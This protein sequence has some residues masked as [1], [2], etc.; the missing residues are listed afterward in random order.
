MHLA[1][2][3]Y[4]DLGKSFGLGDSVFPESQLA[5]EVDIGLVGIRNPLGRGLLRD[6]CVTGAAEVR[7]WREFAADQVKRPEMETGWSPT[8]GLS[9]DAHNE[10]LTNY[11][12]N[13]PIESCEL[14][15]FAIGTVFVRLEFESGLPLGC[16]EGVSRCF[17]FAAYTPEIGRALYN[18]AQERVT[19]ALGNKPT[20]LEALSERQI[21]TSV[22]DTRYVELPLI[23]SFTD[24]ILCTDSGDDAE[25]GRA[26]ETLG[27]RANLITDTSS[28]PHDLEETNQPIRFEY[29]G[30]LHYSWPACLL[31][32]NGWEDSGYP[33]HQQIARMFECIKIAHVFLGTLEAFERLFL[34]EI[35]D[36]VDG[37][38]R[39]TIGG[40]DPSELNRL[41][42]LALAVVNLTNFNLVTPTDED[43]AYFRHFDQD[44]H[45]NRRQDLIT[46]ACET[47]YNVQTAE[48]QE[49]SSERQNLLSAIL[50][51]LASLTVVSVSADAYNFVRESGTIIDD[52]FTRTRL[53]VEFVMAVAILAMLAVII[54]RSG[55]HRVSE[56]LD[57]LLAENWWVLALRGIFGVL[58]G[59]AV[60]LL[61]GMAIA[62][63]VLLFAG[64]ILADGILAIVV[65]V[66]ARREKRWSL[67]IFEG[68]AG[69]VAGIIAVL[70][71]V[72]TEVVFAFLLAVWA[73]LSGGLMVGTAF[74]LSVP[75]GRWWMV[76]SGGVSMLWG[77][78]LF[79][80][81]VAGVLLL[82][83]WLGAYGL[84]FGVLLLVLA[85]R[86]K[87]RRGTTARH[88]R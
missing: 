46:E 73:L 40:R 59:V 15:I 23:T 75:Y 31:Q 18:A 77:T 86:L 48:I 24:V 82:N 62:S 50:F 79:L 67:P 8:L 68:A 34:D 39:G 22:D 81:P 29:H 44:A 35:R 53:L 25:I 13:H 1:L 63:L 43:Q 6:L 17:E 4:F 32:P 10:Q 2:I 45:I 85:L 65:G 20:G 12:R 5:P 42:T 49:E 88:A 21:P 47:V 33:A 70:W 69:I 84:A 14:T 78:L 76:L 54:S 52:M 41:R 51:V 37:Y 28:D 7:Q 71:P 27:M 30:W 64:Y 9:K 66:R 56:T 19:D 57:A 38:V 26:L 55:K 36:Q 60:L 87:G 72:I 80:A 16:L 58:F 74:R 83:W 3:A 11:I 61:P